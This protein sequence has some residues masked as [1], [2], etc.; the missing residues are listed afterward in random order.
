[1]NR[2]PRPYVELVLHRDAHR[3]AWCRDF[4]SGERGWD[5]SIHHRRA[6]GMGGDKRYD[7]N[8][9]SNLVLVHGN[10]TV[11][12]HGEI[13]SR[14]GDAQIRGFLIPKLSFDPA[15]A[16]S[17]DHAFHGWCYLLEDGSISDDPPEES[18]A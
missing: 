13:E 8:F 1:V 4:V 18:C 10:G 5:W 9:P 6:G 2:V 11:G 15:A 17:I 14:R 3:C 16:F 12:C 7:A